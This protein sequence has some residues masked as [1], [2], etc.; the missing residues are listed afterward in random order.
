MYLPRNVYLCPHADR[1]E[2]EC[3]YRRAVEAGPMERRAQEGTI[4]GGRGGA[5]QNA[6]VIPRVHS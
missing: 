6:R 3:H 4:S 1:G 2:H 5:Q